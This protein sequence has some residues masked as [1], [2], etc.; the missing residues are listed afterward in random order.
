MTLYVADH[1]PLSLVLGLKSL[2][3][4]EVSKDLTTF[5]ATTF[6]ST[7]S[8]GS[9]LSIK[10]GSVTSEMITMYVPVQCTR[11]NVSYW[12]HIIMIV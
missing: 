2:S 8:L 10:G 12:H 11:T 3:I 5:D 7:Y 6:T 4:L 9:L 1:F